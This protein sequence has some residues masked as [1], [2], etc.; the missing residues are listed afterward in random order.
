MFWTR[1]GTSQRDRPYSAATVTVCGG[2]VN[3]CPPFSEEYVGIRSLAAGREMAALLC[4]R[5]TRAILAELS[6]RFG[7]RHPDSLAYL[8]RRAKKREGESAF[9]RHRVALAESRR[10]TK[11]EN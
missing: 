5:Y 2:Q 11:T 1:D 3:A 6:E 9:Y 8:V 7:L 10:A 4:R